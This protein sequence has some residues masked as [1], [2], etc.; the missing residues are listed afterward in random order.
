LKANQ[1]RSLCK[2]QKIFVL[3]NKQQQQKEE[4]KK[5]KVPRAE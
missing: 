3:Y 1:L 4:R 2:I 5:E